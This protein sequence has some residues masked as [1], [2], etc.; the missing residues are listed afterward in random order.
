MTNLSS[1]P[2]FGSGGSGASGDLPPILTD[3]PTLVDSDTDYIRG[4]SYDRQSSST[5]Q[6]FHQLSNDG[7]FAG[8]FDPYN[9]S[10]NGGCMP[11]GFYV[12]P[13]NGSMNSLQRGSSMYNSGSGDTFSTCH[14]GAI[15][16][17]VLN[18]GHHRNPN[19]GSTYKGWL[20]GATFA[21][22]GSS[23]HNGNSQ[24]PHEYWPHSNGDLMLH[25]DSA[26]GNAYGRRS[27][28]NQGTGTYYHNLFY[29]T[30]TGSAASQQEWTQASNTSTNYTNQAA[31]QSRSD[32]QPGGMLCYQDTSSNQYI[33]PCYGSTLS[34]GTTYNRS[35]LGWT[36]NMQGWHL[37]D[38]K[39]LWHYEGKWQLQNS[40]TLSDLSSEPENGGYANLM[41]NAVYMN[42]MCVPCN[43]EADTWIAT[44]SGYGLL[45]FKIH[46][47]DN[48]RFE[49]LGVFNT[50]GW[51][52]DQSI[53]QSG[54]TLGLVGQNDEYLVYC[55]VRNGLCPT[56]R[57]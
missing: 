46:V 52:Y 25:A 57:L 27:G 47:N 23:T 3:I 54:R 20:Y 39:T 40:N 11:C 22:D 1:L 34:R 29:Y 38:G 50:M 42:R 36:D 48:Y 28:Y 21:N 45:K 19:Y 55:R 32:L 12:N 30:G 10:N 41:S 37:S 2:G 7:T 6:A 5:Y 35:R 26:T 51:I 8:L 13:S 15:G 43:S 18:N 56:L 33:E 4:S 16:M 49:A 44:T 31:K 17:M 14:H 53:S 9:S 24:G